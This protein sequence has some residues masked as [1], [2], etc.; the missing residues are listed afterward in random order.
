LLYI[1]TSGEQDQRIMEYQRRQSAGLVD[2]QAQRRIREL[3]QNCQRLL[4][5][6]TVRNPFAT[7]LKLPEE[8]FK[9][10]RTLPL[11]LLFIETLTWYHQYQRELKTDE[12]TGEQFIESTPEDIEAAFMLLET[13]LLK[14]SDELNDACRNFFEKLKSWLKSKKAESFHARDVRRELRLAPSSLKR[15][16][17][18]LDR[19]GYL[20][21]SG[22]S[23][24]RGF[25]YKVTS[26]NELEEL[27]GS[28][29]SLVAGVLDQI[30]SVAR[31]PAVAQSPG[32][33]LK[34]L[35]AGPKEAVARADGKM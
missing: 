29:A 11:L 17:W 24:Y 18:E 19:M 25:E 26:W 10:R 6:I 4:K 16:L 3:I 32:G 7:Y 23:K 5:P 31:G 15:Y 14:K 1:D 35:K 27:K 28:A 30:K 22:G 20:R 12:T 34:R 33:P 2:D 13:T 8:V 9:P 21:I